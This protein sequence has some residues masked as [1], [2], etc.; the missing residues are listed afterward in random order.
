[1]TVRPATVEPRSSPAAGAVVLWCVLAGA[2]VSATLLIEPAETRGVEFLSPQ[3]ALR[4]LADLVVLY[5]LFIVPL[6]AW[7]KEKPLRASLEAAGIVCFTAAVGL[8]MI[9]KLVGYGA[10]RMATLIGFVALSAAG[11]V[12]WA[13][14][15]REKPAVYYGVAAIAGFGAP[16]MQFLAAEVLRIDASWLEWFSPFTGWRAIV[17]AGSW[18]PWAVFAAILLVGAAG[19]AFKFRRAGA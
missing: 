10:A 6:F 15:C 14:A 5:V 19:L 7:G 18:A 3:G 8:V 16:L 9:D 13:E 1:M 17:D 2:V 4:L 11:A 12:V